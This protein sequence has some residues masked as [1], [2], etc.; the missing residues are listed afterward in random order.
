MADE[1]G[2]DFLEFRLAPAFLNRKQDE[3][4]GAVTACNNVRAIADQGT[5]QLLQADPVGVWPINFYDPIPDRPKHALGIGAGLQ[6]QH[7][8][9]TVLGPVT[10]G[11]GAAARTGK[12]GEVVAKMRCNL[13][14]K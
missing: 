10:A 14:V 9:K 13:V 4:A 3:L 1:S 8:T 6:D 2:G 12:Q 11:T 7:A 5:L